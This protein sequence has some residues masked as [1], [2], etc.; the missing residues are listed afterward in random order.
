MKSSPIWLIF[1]LVINGA[2]TCFRKNQAIAKK[3]T[4]EKP[5][6]LKVSGNMESSETT[7]EIIH[8][9]HFWTLRNIFALESA[10]VR[11]VSSKTFKVV[12]D[13]GADGRYT[14]FR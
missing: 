10:Q 2:F 1:A 12:C 6:A 5:A 13:H 8:G 4:E 9:T 7:F 3:I 14:N 11:E